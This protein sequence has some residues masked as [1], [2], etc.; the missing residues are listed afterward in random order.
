MHL[1]A[2]NGMLKKYNDALSVIEDYFPVRLEMY[3]KRRQHLLAQTTMKIN[4]LENRIQ[5]CKL[6][7]GG[8]ISVGKITKNELIED[9]KTRNFMPVDGSY[10]YLLNTPV[11]NLTKD[12]IEKLTSE[13]NEQQTENSALQNSKDVDL[14][15]RELQDLLVDINKI[16]GTK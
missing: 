16:S 1:F 7:T 3:E 15:K 14:W 13:K 12:R 4:T 10:D 11:W 2:P 9:L 5:F 6:V 8:T